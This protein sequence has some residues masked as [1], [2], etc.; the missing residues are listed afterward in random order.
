MARK[1]YKI[2]VGRKLFGVCGGF[3]EYLNLDPTIVRLLW[4]VLALCWGSGILLY[5]LCAIILPNKSEVE[6]N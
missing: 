1:L 4:V 2:E 3:A 6:F 5:I